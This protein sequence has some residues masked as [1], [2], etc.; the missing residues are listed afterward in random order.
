[1]LSRSRLRLVGAAAA[2]GSLAAFIMTHGLFLHLIPFL[3]PVLFMSAPVVGGI[4][5]RQ[6]ARLGVGGAILVALCITVANT[7]PYLIVLPLVLM[8]QHLFA[9][10]ETAQRVTTVVIWIVGLFVV[11]SMVGSLAGILFRHL[12]PP[13]SRVTAELAWTRRYAI[14]SDVLALADRRP[15]LATLDGTAVHTVDAYRQNLN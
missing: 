10:A 1:V 2:H 11:Y 14:T 12:R 5:A 4:R 3:S 15:Q 8:N 7:F 13:K 9:D 6:R